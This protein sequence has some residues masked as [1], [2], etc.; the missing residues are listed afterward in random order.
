MGRTN[1]DNWMTF[2]LNSW[3]LG[4]EAATVVGLRMAKL[5]MGGPG[6]AQEAQRMVAEKI[7]EAQSLNLRAMTGALGQSPAAVANASVQQ[8]RR[9]V[10]ANR[11]RLSKR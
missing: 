6:A 8:V 7:A 11:R 4:Y 9:K 5:A 2:G 10:R 3:M 1:T